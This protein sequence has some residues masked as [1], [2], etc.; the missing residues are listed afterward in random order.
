MSDSLPAVL[1]VAEV[2]GNGPVIICINRLGDAVASRL[3]LD[4]RQNT[5]NTT[6]IRRVRDCRVTIFCTYQ[7]SPRGIVVGHLR[8]QMMA[9]WQ[10][11][12]DFKTYPAI[13]FS[14]SS[15]A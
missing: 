4:V 14:D 1:Q 3:A 10:F 9:A 5:Q 11:L 7:F 13:H 8:W 15:G 6:Q 2:E 12:A